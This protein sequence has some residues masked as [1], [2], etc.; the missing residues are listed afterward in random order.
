M[1]RLEYQV[2]AMRKYPVAIKEKDALK[3]VNGWLLGYYFYNAN[4]DEHY[5]CSIMPN[6]LPVKIAPET[7]CR[8]SGF[9]LCD[10]FMGDMH[11]LF[12]GDIVEYRPYDGVVGYGVIRFGEFYVSG[13]GIEED[14]FA[15]GIGWFIEHTPPTVKYFKMLDYGNSHGLM[16]DEGTLNLEYTYTG[17]DIFHNPEYLTKEVEVSD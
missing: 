8:C 17:C 3:S 14:G 12:E 16:Y 15:E 4:D 1:N 2:R 7:V 5:I 11:T 6:I 10:D 13:L 9:S